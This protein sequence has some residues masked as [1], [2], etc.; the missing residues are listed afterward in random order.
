MNRVKEL[1]K[2]NK[3]VILYLIF[4]G[5]TTLVNIIVYSICY[6]QI[7]TGNT[8]ANII[9]WI[10]S[11]IFVYITNKLFVFE[12]KTSGI[13]MLIKEVAQFFSCRL[14]TGVLDILIMLIFVDVLLLPALVFKIISN[15]LVIILN[16]IA[17]KLVIFKN[18]G[19]E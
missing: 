9:A 15:V 10:L 5:L 14:A 13:G 18:K 2:K 12:S 1:I 16:Y 4:G 3:S 8:E 6:Y 7:E 11:V 19:E 17:S